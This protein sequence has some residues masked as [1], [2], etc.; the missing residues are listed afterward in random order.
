MKKHTIHQKVDKILQIL[1]QHTRKF[2]SIDDRF[3]SMDDRFESMDKTMNIRFLEMNTRFTEMNI[4][5]IEIEKQ[6]IEMDK[7]FGKIDTRLDKHDEQFES[8]EA[9][10]ERVILKLIEHDSRFD[11]CVT[12]KEFKAYMDQNAQDHDKIFQ[13]LERFDHERVCTNAGLRRTEDQ[14]QNHEK[15]ITKVEVQL[16]A[17]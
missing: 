16:T 3:E 8:I 12:K 14:V 17:A 1:E 10:F 15:R 9:K 11:Q 7:R 6:F 13:L 2:E 5:F 4:Q